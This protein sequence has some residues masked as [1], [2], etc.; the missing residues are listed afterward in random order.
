MGTLPSLIPFSGFFY[1][2]LLCCY[3]CRTLFQIYCL[4]SGSTL[5][6]LIIWIAAMGFLVHWLSPS[7]GRHR[8]RRGWEKS[9]SGYGQ[10]PLLRPTVP[11]ERSSPCSY[12]SDSINYTLH[13]AFQ[14]FWKGFSSYFQSVICLLQEP[15]LILYLIINQLI[16]FPF[17]VPMSCSFLI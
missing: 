5:R 11:V 13:L 9:E 14:A 1:L 4:T 3:F 12:F 10:I 16:N 15:W 7:N 2:Y 6:G 17:C 8:Q